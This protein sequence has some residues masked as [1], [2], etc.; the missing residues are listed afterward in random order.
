MDAK[1]ELIVKF[2]FDSGLSCYRI[3][4]LADVPEQTV[5]DLAHGRTDLDRMQLGTAVKLTEAAADWYR[6]H[7]GEN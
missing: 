1:K 7:K 5:R 4:K 6:S 2:V 3:A